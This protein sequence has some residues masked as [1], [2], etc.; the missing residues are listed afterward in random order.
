M[1]KAESKNNSLDTRQMNLNG[2]L[3]NANDELCDVYMAYKDLEQ[4]C[5]IDFKNIQSN[6]AVAGEDEENPYDQ[7][8]TPN[9][10]ES[11]RSSQV[12]ED[13]A[14]KKPKTKVFYFKPESFLLVDPDKQRQY[15]E[16]LL[17]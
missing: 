9:D 5:T 7:S 4:R 16:K 3:E 1:S 2:S 15:R 8:E 14:P 10:S 12:E 11:R 13:Q 6:G 17:S